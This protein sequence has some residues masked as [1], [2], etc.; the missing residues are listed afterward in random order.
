MKI[1]EFTNTQLAPVAEKFNIEDAV[2]LHNTLNPKI[3][4]KGKMRPEVRTA[5]LDIADNFKSFL[6]IDDIESRD[7]IGV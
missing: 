3:W 7:D 2:S 5:L 1:T 4:V 6:G